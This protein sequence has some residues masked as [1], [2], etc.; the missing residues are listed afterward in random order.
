MQSWAHMKLVCQTGEFIAENSSNLALRK[1]R[2]QTEC[3]KVQDHFNIHFR[4][5]H[6]LMYIMCHFWSQVF[7]CYRGRLGPAQSKPSS[8][9]QYKVHT[10][11]QMG[12]S[13]TLAT[14]LS[15]HPYQ[16]PQNASAIAN[17]AAVMSGPDV[18]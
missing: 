15:L 9:L 1:V 16:E 11:L 17:I 12:S 8:H 6:L 14:P 2:S 13:G 10:Y 18:F 4:Y 7:A 5:V 3:P